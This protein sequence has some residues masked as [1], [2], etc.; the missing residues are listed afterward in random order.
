MS[1]SISTDVLIIGGGLVGASLGIA[2]ASGGVRAL[3]VDRADPDMVLKAQFDG[4]TSALAFGSRRLYE[5]TGVWAHLQADAQP[6]WQIRVADGTSPFF[7]HFDHACVSAQ[8]PMG[9]IVE[10]LAIRHALHKSLPFYADLLDYRA[11]CGVTALDR[12][13]G[14]VSAMLDDG[15]E[16]SAQ[17]TVAA[18]GRRSPTRDAAGIKLYQWDYH[19]S[20]IVCSVAHTV[21]HN[22]VAVEHF[23]SAGPFAILPLTGNRSGLVW[24]ENNDRAGDFMSLDDTAFLNEIR[25]RFDGY[26]GELELIGPR[27]CYPLSLQHAYTYISERLALVGDSAHGMHPIAGQGFN[28]GLRDVA[29]LAEVLGEAKCLGLDLGSR[30]LLKDYERKRRADNTM[31]LAATDL[32]NRLFSNEM[33]PVKAARNLGLG[34]VNRLEPLKRVFVKNAMGQM[35]RLPKLMRGERI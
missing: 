7:V 11:P 13:P 3:V 4:R 17:L 24:T 21:P 23:Q 31:M 10:N 29:V 35:G 32:L 18:D 5:A 6:I 25:S 27:F 20:G 8:D 28:M 19:Q 12:Q 33:P 22:G 1:K 15:T 26:L 30:L 14:K 34:V 2:L 9:Y 16:V